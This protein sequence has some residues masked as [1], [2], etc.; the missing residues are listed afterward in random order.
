M[1]GTAAM[2]SDSETSAAVTSVGSELIVKSYF[3]VSLSSF[4]IFAMPI[5]VGPLRV[6]TL[7]T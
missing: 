5:P 3:F 2:S 7:R 1:T 6:A 4:I